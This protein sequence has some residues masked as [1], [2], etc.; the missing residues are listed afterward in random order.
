[1]II[2]GEKQNLI[3]PMVINSHKVACLFVMLQSLEQ[4]SAY[5]ARMRALKELCDKCLL[6]KK[7]VIAN[8]VPD[9]DGYVKAN[10]GGA[11]FSPLHDEARRSTTAVCSSDLFGTGM[12][13]IAIRNDWE[14]GPALKGAACGFDHVDMI[15]AISEAQNEKRVYIYD[16]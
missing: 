12:I 13:H 2:E 8:V 15:T 9:E 1:M 11:D 4:D 10:E 5:I 16:K 3:H 7:S 14:I 6:N